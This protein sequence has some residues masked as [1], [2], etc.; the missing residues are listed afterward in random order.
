MED[1]SEV[2]SGSAGTIKKLFPRTI[3]NPGDKYIGDI[4]EYNR[5]EIREKV[6]TE[7]IFRFGVESGVVTNNNTPTNTSLSNGIETY[8]T[9][10]PLKDLEGYYYTPFKTIDVRKFSTVIETAEPD[11]II[12]GIPGDYETYSDGSRAWRDLLTDGFI[13]EGNNGVD[14]PFLNGKHY[15]YMNSNIYIRRQNPYNLIDQSDIISVNPKNAC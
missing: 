6:I 14:W 8:T 11:D 15:L 9:A 4:V 10:S 12:E 2:S 1:V 3:T 7:V 13:E 5:K